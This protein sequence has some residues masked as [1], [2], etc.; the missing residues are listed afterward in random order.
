MWFRYNFTEH[1]KKLKCYENIEILEIK[2]IIKWIYTK[3]I[4]L[5]FQQDYI[6]DNY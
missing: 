6:R 2:N 1:K 5:W 3:I 4:N